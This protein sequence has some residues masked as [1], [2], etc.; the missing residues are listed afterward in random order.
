VA[1]GDAHV[2]LRV[3]PLKSRLITR[4]SSP[5]RGHAGTGMATGFISGIKD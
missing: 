5:P 3:P 2:G 1:I 4:R